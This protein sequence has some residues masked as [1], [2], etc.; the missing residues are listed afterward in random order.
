MID[1]SGTSGTWDRSVISARYNID[2]TD[3]RDATYSEIAAELHRRAD[4][5]ATQHG[6]ATF[7]G[8]SYGSPS[9][10]FHDPEKPKRLRALADLLERE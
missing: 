8:D 1:E 10:P 9:P 4:V 5:H 2:L 3:L 7:G 6:M